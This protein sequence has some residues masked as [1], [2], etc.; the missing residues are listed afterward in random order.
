[1]EMYKQQMSQLQQQ[2][3]KFQQ[4]IQ[5]PGNPFDENPGTSGGSHP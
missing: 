3:L 5:W 1:M 2:M 4:Q